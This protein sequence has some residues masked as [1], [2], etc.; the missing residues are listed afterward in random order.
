MQRRH[1]LFVLAGIAAQT[2]A[3]E[4]PVKPTRNLY[5]IWGSS[6][7][8]VFLVGYASGAVGLI[9]HSQDQGKTWSQPKSNTTQE[10]YSIWG[11]SEKNIYA[12]GAH[13]TILRSIDNGKTWEKQKSPTKKT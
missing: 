1:F 8:N 10:L 3:K 11:S 9:L 13:G 7:K 12:V 2:T 6:A 5:A 4:E